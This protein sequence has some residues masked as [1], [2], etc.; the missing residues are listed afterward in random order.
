[1]LDIFIIPEELFESTVIF[2][3]LTN[4]LAIFQ[5]MINELLRDMINTGKVESFI[6]NVIVGIEGIES[7]ERYN[8]LVEEIL[9]RM[10]ENDL[11]VKLK[12]CK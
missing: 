8:K 9:R 10:E 11:Y 7:K 1:M 2:F 4:S 6:D 5:V 3:G 12:K